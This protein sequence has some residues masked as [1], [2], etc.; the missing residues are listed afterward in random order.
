MNNLPTRKQLKERKKTESPIEGLLLREL[1]LLGIYP[2]SQFKVGKYRLDLAFPEKMIGIECDGKEWHTS[3]EQI[4]RDTKR[5]DYLKEQGWNI[6]RIFGS[7]IYKSAGEI[8]L[9]LTEEKEIP[10]RR[11]E[12]YF[13]RTTEEY[14]EQKNEFSELEEKQFPELENEE[15]DLGGMD[16]DTFFKIG[17]VIKNRYRN[18]I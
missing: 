13:D 1:Q 4:E 14:L 6:L 2:I 11:K 7:D 5:D 10:N 15:E 17:D 16:I 3:E 12:I 9:F 8:A 18:T